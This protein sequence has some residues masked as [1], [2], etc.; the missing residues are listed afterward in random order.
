[1]VG[2]GVAP[3][4]YVYKTLS[5]G[6][7]LHRAF[8]PVSIN[9]RVFHGNVGND[10]KLISFFLLRIA[11]LGFGVALFFCFSLPTEWVEISFLFSPKMV[12]IM[13]KKYKKCQ[14]WQK[15]MFSV[16]VVLFQCLLLEQCCSNPATSFIFF[17]EI[18]KKRGGSLLFPVDYRFLFRVSTPK[19]TFD[20]WLAIQS[21]DLLA[22]PTFI[23]MWYLAGRS[24][25]SLSCRPVQIQTYKHTYIYIC[26]L[27]K[28]NKTWKV[29]QLC[30]FDWRVKKKLGKEIHTFF[31]S[32]FFCHPSLSLPHVCCSR[33]GTWHVWRLSKTV[34]HGFSLFFF[35]S[36]VIIYSLPILFWGTW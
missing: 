25:V 17:W 27:K 30:H 33:L 31:L 1:M 14:P 2:P 32:W 29:V 11:P 10:P 36:L 18:K 12:Q 16:V 7:E 15:E 9:H 26:R 13:K 24:C 35:L 3:L 6:V 5:A 8:S 28:Q 34:S 4:F 22:P 21:S 23:H 20:N 19:S